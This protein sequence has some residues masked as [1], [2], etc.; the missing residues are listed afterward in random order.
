MLEIRISNNGEKIPVGMATDQIFSWGVGTGTGLGSWQTKNIVEHFGGSIEFI[1]ND[2]AA[3]GFY[4][5]YR[6]LLPITD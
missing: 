1:Q 5:E 3:D 6:I 2:D 4:I